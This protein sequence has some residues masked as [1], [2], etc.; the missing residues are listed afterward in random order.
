[1]RINLSAKRGSFIL[2][3]SMTLC[4]ARHCSATIYG[5]V[6]TFH[7]HFAF[8]GQRNLCESH[9][10]LNTQSLNL[11]LLNPHA[12]RFV[13]FHSPSSAWMKELNENEICCRRR[14]RSDSPIAWTQQHCRQHCSDQ[15]LGQPSRKLDRVRICIAHKR[16][17]IHFVCKLCKRDF[18]P[19]IT[20]VV[21][22]VVAS[23]AGARDY[24]AD[25]VIY[26]RIANA[27]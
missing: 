4:L 19:V 14:K 12:H 18:P 24:R 15:E 13:R 21:V 26:M 3:V 1:M 5:S 7:W 25:A 17:S 23:Y 16:D 10:L 22:C 2:C 8:I 11:L 27:Q 20:G 9:F 6:A